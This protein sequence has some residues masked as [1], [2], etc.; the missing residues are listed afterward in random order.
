MNKA[1]VIPPPSIRNNMNSRD[2][3]YKT[4]DDIKR[5]YNVIEK[6]LD[7]LKDEKDLEKRTAILDS[8]EQYLNETQSLL[9]SVDVSKAWTPEEEN[10]LNR[11]KKNLGRAKRNLRRL[12]KGLELKEK[13]L[14]EPKENKNS[15]LK[16]LNEL[17]ENSPEDK[18]K[19][20]KIQW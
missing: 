5:R 20:R 1:G 12:E 6:A 7:S 13:E 14:N 8:A 18:K 15:P 9:A 16:G 17:K 11:K 4:F 2:E 19:I 3:L 10:D